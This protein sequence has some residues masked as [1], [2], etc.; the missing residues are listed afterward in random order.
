[1]GHPVLLYYKIT[2]QSG[3]SRRWYKKFPA[4]SATRKTSVKTTA[5]ALITCNARQVLS[6]SGED[7]ESSVSPVCESGSKWYASASVVKLN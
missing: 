7:E 2:F 3:S 5:A 1:M 6:N 4:T